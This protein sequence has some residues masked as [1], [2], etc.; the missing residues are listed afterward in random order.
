VSYVQTVLQPGEAI[1]FQ[2]NVHWFVYLNSILTMV[3][4]LASFIAFKA[5][6][7]QHTFLLLLA[8]A[9]GV[10]SVTLFVPAWLKRFGT[11]I[12][13]TD[14]RIIHKT[15]LIQ[16]Q[17]TETNMAKVESVD[18]SQSILGRLFDY[19]T[20]TVRGTGES[21]APL[22]NVA[23]PIELRNAVLVR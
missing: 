14:R 19:G 18:V 10:A 23:S 6:D 5:T 22:R 20:V 4:A 15:G 11:E 16:R 9:L 21:S 13:V 3:L 2:T 17:T 12:A 8:G 7:D 1:R